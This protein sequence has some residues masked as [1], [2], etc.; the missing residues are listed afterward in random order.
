[1]RVEVARDLKALPEVM[2]LV[3]RFL[4]DIGAGQNAR[5]PVQLA[6]EEVFTN[7]VRHNASGKAGL[8]LGLSLHDGEI[9]ITLTDFDTPRF[10]LIA[11]APPV[12]TSAPLEN[13]T[14]GGLGIHL[15]KKMMDRIEY[16][17]RNRTGTITLRKRMG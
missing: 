4:G 16:S 10:N 15:V 2:Q 1:M 11:D 6:V 13:R 14:P 12:D 7:M 17:H 8:E 5:F 3:D 9:V